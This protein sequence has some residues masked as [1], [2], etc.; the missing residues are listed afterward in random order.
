[1]YDQC[2]TELL[3]LKYDVLNYLPWLVGLFFDHSCAEQVSWNLNVTETV[4]TENS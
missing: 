1:M 4:A 2:L 3:F